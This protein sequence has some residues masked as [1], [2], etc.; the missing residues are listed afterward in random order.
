[1]NIFF[2]LTA[3]A[4]IIIVWGGLAFFLSKALRYEKEKIGKE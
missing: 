2:I 4:V 1:V 3:A